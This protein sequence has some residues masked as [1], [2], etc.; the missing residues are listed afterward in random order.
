MEQT[1][2][3]PW[4]AVFTSNY[5]KFEK[6]ILKTIVIT[7]WTL[8][9]TTKEYDAGNKTVWE[10]KAKVTEENDKKVD[11][12]LGISSMPFLLKARPIL[13]NRPTTDKVKIQVMKMGD[14]KNTQYSVK[15][16]K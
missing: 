10:L 2:K 3:N 4:E 13:E 14:G 7:E 9:Q 15:E 11:M 6:E 16:I 12:T 8:E 5:V 1:T